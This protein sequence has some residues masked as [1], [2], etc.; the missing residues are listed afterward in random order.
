M[1]FVGVMFDWLQPLNW[2]S[3]NT[4]SPNKMLA[5]LD[6][7]VCVLV[8]YRANMTHV[9]TPEVHFEWKNLPPQQVSHTLIRAEPA[10]E[11]D[12]HLSL[13]RAGM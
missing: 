3:Q 12:I 10:G 9:R 1:L 8:C 13:V 6:Q 5:M 4:H 11:F 2:I 7:A